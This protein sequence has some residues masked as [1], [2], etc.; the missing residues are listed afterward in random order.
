MRMCGNSH[1]CTGNDKVQVTRS[2]GTGKVQVTR[3]LHVGVDVGVC[4][5]F[6]LFA[7]NCCQE[8]L[9][10]NLIPLCLLCHLLG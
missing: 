2:T 8:S 4:Q 1:I 7:N 10:E 3:S 5:E 6:P 9:Y